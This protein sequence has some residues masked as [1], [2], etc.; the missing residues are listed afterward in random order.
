MEHF[1]ITLRPY[2]KWVIDYDDLPL[3]NNVSH[4]DKAQA[5]PDEKD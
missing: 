3:R 5:K 4:A 2:F 1:Y